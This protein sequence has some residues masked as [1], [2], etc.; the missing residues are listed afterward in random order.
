MPSF[1]LIAM[2][3]KKKEYDISVMSK[4]ISVSLFAFS[5]FTF[6]KGHYEHSS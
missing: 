1:S 4:H 6:I 3:H 5:N 2:N